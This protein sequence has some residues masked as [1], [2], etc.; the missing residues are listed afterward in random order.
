MLKH[1]LIILWN[2]KRKYS[3]LIFEQMLVFIAVA[4]SLTIVFDTVKSYNTPGKLNIDNVVGF[5]Y[6][7]SGGQGK[8]QEMKEMHQLMDLVKERLAGEAYVTG[9]SRSFYFTPFL[10]PSEDYYSD[11]VELASGKK[12]FAHIKATDEAAEKIY[13]PDIIRGRWFRDGERINGNYPVVVSMPFAELSGLSDVLGKT[14]RFGG[15]TFTVTGIVSGIKEVP[16]EETP[17]CVIFPIEFIFPE[18]SIANY[19]ELVAKIQPGY[20]DEFTGDLYREYYHVVGEELGAECI[21][22]SLSILETSRMAQS[23]VSIAATGIPAL[24]FLLFTIIGTAGMNLMEAKDRLKEFAL[25]LSC[26]S[27]KKM[28]VCLVVIQ[29]TV[30][31]VLSAIPG[32]AIILS[33][34]P[35]GI[36]LPVAAVTLVLAIFISFLCAM[37]PAVRLSGINPAEQLKEE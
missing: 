11:S 12:V 8:I 5:G 28:A 36:S 33:I 19:E 9:I 21:V 10:R 34:Y 23:T 17:P 15:G 31:T 6:M 25:R 7:V 18:G 22:S 27:T 3:V 30:V 20:E 13:E 14:I 1:I 29:N 4:L 16:Y 2:Q 32:I 37:Y 35:A 24:F 26:G